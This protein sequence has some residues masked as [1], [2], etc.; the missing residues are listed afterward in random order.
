MIKTLCAIH[1]LHLGYHPAAA[2]AAKTADRSFLK[3]A[4][5]L[6]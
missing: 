1:G 2:D 3:A 4:F 6:D 5:R